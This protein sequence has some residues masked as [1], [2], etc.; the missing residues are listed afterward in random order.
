MPRCSRH[1]TAVSAAPG[2]LR[3]CA[4]LTQRRKSGVSASCIFDNSGWD[5]AEPRRRDVVVGLGGALMAA[6]VPLNARADGGGW[7]LD[8]CYIESSPAL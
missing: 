1:E 3:A 7:L 2:Q 4:Q 6:A 8:L 5:P